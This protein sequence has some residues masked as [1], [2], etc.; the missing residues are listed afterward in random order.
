MRRLFLV[1]I[2]AAVVVVPYQSTAGQTSFWVE[3]QTF[4]SDGKK[5]PKIHTLLLQDFNKKH[6]GL[7]GYFQVQ[8]DYAQAYVGPTLSPVP[9]LQA[10]VGGGL[11]QADTPVRLGSFVWMGDAHRYLLAIYENGGGG[12][13]YHA[14][15]NASI[16]DWF[17][18]GA[19]VEHLIGVGPRA[20]LNIPR[21]PAKIWVASLYDWSADGV[22]GLL[23]FRLSF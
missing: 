13:W 11:E 6:L 16:T 19:V 2:M 15:A 5:V 20:E 23:A 18:A 12:Y 17:G 7:F 3:E 10:G 14:E 1:V 9:W 8:E 22:S 4:F 21:L